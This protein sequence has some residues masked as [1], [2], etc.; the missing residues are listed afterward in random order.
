MNNREDI[1]IC[2]VDGDGNKR[3]ILTN[4]DGSLS[5][6]GG[7]GSGGS[8]I[9][10]SQV[11]AAV[12]DAAN[13]QN[14]DNLPVTLGSSSDAIAPNA[15]GSFSLVSLVKFI[16]NTLGFI[17]SVQLGLSTDAAPVDDNVNNFL[18]GFR[19][20]VQRLATIQERLPI[21]TDN[22]RIPTQNKPYTT[23]IPVFSLTMP[24]GTTVTSHGSLASRTR[25]TV[26]NTG[27]FP[28]YCDV[29]PTLSTTDYLFILNPKELYVDELYLG[30]HY[31]RCASGE[32]SVIQIREW[33]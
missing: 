11:Q 15:T 3:K 22:D 12:E 8:G 18:A 29:V 31:F 30:V 33:Q 27:N 20:I 13:L 2:G 6:S 28:V 24:I 4:P 5:I 7:G 10:Q 23:I 32:N 21:L 9:T 14:L 16:A 25:I 26:T 1:L 19:R 17:Q